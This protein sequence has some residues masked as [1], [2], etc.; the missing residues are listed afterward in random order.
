VAAFLV[1]CAIGVVAV[2]CVAGPVLAPWSLRVRYLA[3]QVPDP[4]LGMGLIPRLHMRVVTLADVFA[5]DGVVELLV[6][7]DGGAG[8][9]GCKLSGAA[10]SPGVLARLD[11]WA[12][13]SIPLLMLVDDDG[14]WQLFG[15]DG[16]VT[17]RD[18]SATQIR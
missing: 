16:G 7:D 6:V 8:A 18:V 14:D 17:R 1:G 4:V 9:G 10:C 2:L 12:T 5:A 15:P 3:T 11:G 13:L